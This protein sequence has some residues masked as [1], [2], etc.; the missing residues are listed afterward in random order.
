MIYTKFSPTNKVV[1]ERTDKKGVFMR[2][3]HIISTVHTES[4]M[5]YQFKTIEG[6]REFVKAISYGL[7]AVIVGGLKRGHSK[8]ASELTRV[9][10]ESLKK[11]RDKKEPRTSAVEHTIK[12]SV[13]GVKTLIP[14]S[15]LSY[16]D[17]PNTTDNNTDK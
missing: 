4:R 12:Y 9:S 2:S 5:T 6:K 1:W 13:S 3:E 14:E 16:A 11:I 8:H 10:N 7:A 15:Q 17:M